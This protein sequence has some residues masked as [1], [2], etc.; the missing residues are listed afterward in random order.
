MNYNSVYPWAKHVV[1]H[2]FS[3]FTS[4]KRIERLLHT[5]ALSHSGVKTHVVIPCSSDE[6]ICKDCRDEEPFFF[7]YETFFTKLGVRLPLSLQKRRYKH[8][9]RCPD[10]TSS[11]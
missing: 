4:A 8:H 2:D 3:I 5:H 6:P 1:L 11:Q 10:S 9:K 7:F